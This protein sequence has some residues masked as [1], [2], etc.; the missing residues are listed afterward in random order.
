[1]EIKLKSCISCSHLGKDLHNDN[2]K[3]LAKCKLKDSDIPFFSLNTCYCE[4]YKEIEAT[5]FS[6]GYK[7]NLIKVP[8]TFLFEENETYEN[9]F[10]PKQE[11]SIKEF[12]KNLTF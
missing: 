7:T 2:K 11:F 4:H 8:M 1:M 6:G 5:N 9:F 10:Y 12:N 3:I